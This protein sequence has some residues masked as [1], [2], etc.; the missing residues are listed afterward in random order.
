[1]IDKIIYTV[2]RSKSRLTIIDNSINKM[3]KETDQI[4]KRKQY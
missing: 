4:E 2:Q 3:K 1:M